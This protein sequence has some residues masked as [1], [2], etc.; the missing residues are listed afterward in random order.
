MSKEMKEFEK[1]LARNIARQ[2]SMEEED[3]RYSN[4]DIIKY[5]INY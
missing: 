4:I 1:N 5:N 3:L 2:N